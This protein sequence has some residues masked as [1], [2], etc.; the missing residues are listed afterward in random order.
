VTASDL[1]VFLRTALPDYMIPAQ[2]VLLDGLPRNPHGK[3][4]PARLGE[5]T[6][7]ARE[8]GETYIAPRDD[9]EQR[10]AEI[11]GAVLQLEKVG[12]RTD[13]FTLGGH[14]VLV[15]QAISRIREEFGVEVPI[16]TFF[17]SS[18]IEDLAIAIRNMRERDPLPAPTA[19]PRLA[20]IAR[21]KTADS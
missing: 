12:V 15:I 7:I 19:I 11:W 2:F 1:R 4:D 6:D 20:R 13:F 17:D 5:L 8:G 18:A 16:R 14:S 21:Q 3:V 10:L 9:Y